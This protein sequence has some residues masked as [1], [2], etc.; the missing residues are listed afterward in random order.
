MAM[1]PDGHGLRFPRISARQIVKNRSSSPPANPVNKNIRSYCWESSRNLVTAEE[2]WL[3]KPDLPTTSEILGNDDPNE[4]VFLAPNK[5]SGPWPSKQDYLR[6]QYN[7]IREDA[8]AP[9]RDAVAIVRDSPHMDDTGRISIYQKVH[10][11]VS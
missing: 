7:L 2:R 5:I 8:I 6:T 4:N 11:H 9:L 10:V 1:L 3:Q